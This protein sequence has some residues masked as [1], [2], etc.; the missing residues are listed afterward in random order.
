MIFQ[1]PRVGRFE[2]IPQNLAQIRQVEKLSDAYHFTFGS[3][4]VMVMY[5][6]EVRHQ[7]G[8]RRRNARRGKAEGQGRRRAS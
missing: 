7:G 6:L 2:R 8:A 4:D 1:N 5:L 3:E